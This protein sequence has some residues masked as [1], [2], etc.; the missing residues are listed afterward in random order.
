MRRTHGHALVAA[1]AA[2][3]VVG[4]AWT[5]G[6]AMA[7]PE[8]EAASAYAPGML[9]ALERDLGL[10]TAEAVDLLETQARITEVTE[11]LTES[12]GESYAGS[13]VENSE[14]LTVAVTD[15]AEAAAVERSGAEAVV[16]DHSLDALDAWT[17]DLDEVLAGVDGVPSYSVDV[18]ANTIV[19]GVHEGAKAKAA[20]AI[21]KAGIPADA[22]T[23]RVTD[24]QPRTLIDVVGGNAYY[25]NGTSRCSVGFAA[26][27]GFVTAGHCGNVGASTTS[28]SGTFR[29]SSFP[30]DD[31]GYVA[32]ASG[33]NLVPGVNGYDGNT[34]AVTGHSV[35]PVGTTVCRSGSTTGWHCG[36]VQALNATVNYAQGSVHGLI[37]TSVCAEPGDSGGSLL[38]GNSAQGMTSGGSGNCSSGGTTYFQ[39]VGEAL[40]AAGVSLLTN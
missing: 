24:E 29:T 27:G 20:K 2:L 23:Y 36:T 35:A 9:D 26:T 10:E 1:T 25:I 11:N 8:S 4:G 15:A 22:V 37:R 17:A 18:A 13:W 16:V 14:N 40:S 34:Y 7:A 21:R 6:A 3:T 12:L 28:P 31:Y 39:P 30:G 38:A 33:N 19:V 32:V 5:A